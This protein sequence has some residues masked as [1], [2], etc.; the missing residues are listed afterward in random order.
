MT[1]ATAQ[2]ATLDDR[3]LSTT[4]TPGRTSG[5][6]SSMVHRFLSPANSAIAARV[7]AARWYE[8]PDAGRSF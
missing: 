5:W 3:D 4:A 8:T 1:H 2:D 6:F 7:V